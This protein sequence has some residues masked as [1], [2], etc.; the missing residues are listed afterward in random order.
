MFPQERQ[1]NA[2]APHATQSSKS[3]RPPKKVKIPAQLFLILSKEGGSLKED[4]FLDPIIVSAAETAASDACLADGSIHHLASSKRPRSEQQQQQQQ[5]Q[6]G[7]DE[8]VS[9]VSSSAQHSVNEL[10]AAS[11][12]RFVKELSSYTRAVCMRLGYA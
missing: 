2:G 7:K 10:V 4:G 1:H 6:R 9:S 11:Q 3:S 8:G 12:A 5:Q